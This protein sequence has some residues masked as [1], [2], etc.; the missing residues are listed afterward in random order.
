MVTSTDVCPFQKSS[1]T[2]SIRT[3]ALG[4]SVIG[5]SIEIDSTVG[6]LEVVVS[7]VVSGMLF[8]RLCG[9]LCCST[10]F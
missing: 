1:S 2:V 3:S 8:G 5:V 4:A 9:E 6:W 10:S 7:E